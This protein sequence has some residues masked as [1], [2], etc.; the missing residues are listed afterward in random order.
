MPL[1][2][3]DYHVISMQGQVIARPRGLNYEARRVHTLTIEATD[4]A[5]PANLQR[6]STAVV[7][8]CSTYSS[9]CCFQFGLHVL[10]VAPG[11]LYSNGHIG[12]YERG[13]PL[14]RAN[15]V[16]P[17]YTCTQRSVHWKVSYI[18]RSFNCWR[19]HC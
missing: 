7:I 19:Y 15:E 11:L 12:I 16:V 5:T 3:G 14:F 17:L 18:Q 2:L 1:S 6:F 4:Q 13:H 8:I 10:I 9:I